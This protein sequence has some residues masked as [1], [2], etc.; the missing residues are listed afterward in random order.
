[1]T[2]GARFR[3][4]KNPYVVIA[5]IGI[6]A[7]GNAIGG[8][9]LWDDE[10]VVKTNMFIRQ[11][12]NLPKLLTPDYFAR[13]SVGHYTQ[14]G[15]ESYRPVVTLTHFMDYAVFGLRPWGYHFMNVLF[16]LAASLTLLY[17]FQALNLTNLAAFCAALLFMV[18]PLNSE[19]V[20]MVSYR[21]D[22][23]AGL[24]VSAAFAALL[25]DRLLICS[26]WYIAALLSKES[27]L[28]FALLVG[29]YWF[30]VRPENRRVSICQDRLRKP[31]LPAKRSTSKQARRPS[32]QQPAKGARCGSEAIPVFSVI[33]GISA[34]YLFLV[35]IVFPPLGVADSYELAA[36]PGVIGT[37][38]RVFAKYLQL[39]V[40]PVILR[41]DYTFPVS[42]SIWSLPALGSLALIMG[43][44]GAS[45]LVVRSRLVRF[46]IW[47]F[48]V[49]ALPVSGVYPLKN[50]IA[51]RYLYLPIMGWCGVAGIGIAWLCERYPRTQRWIVVGFALIIIW[52]VGLNIK[53]NRVWRDEISF[54]TEMIRV[55]PDSAKGHSGLGMA[56]FERR[57]YEKAERALRRSL[58]LNPHQTIALHNYGCILME[59]GK[60]HDALAA[61]SQVV[62]RDPNFVEA[63]YQAGMVYKELHE[64]E[65]A[66]VYLR[67]TLDLNPNFIPAKFLL[68]VLHQERQ[69]WSEAV[70]YFEEVIAVDRGHDRAIKNLGIIYYYQVGDMVKA[71]RYLRRYLELVPNDPQRE[72]IVQVIAAAEAL[73]S[74]P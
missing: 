7:Y 25:K 38:A 17:L 20:N 68:G 43:L 45:A 15:E 41:V 37:M 74:N 8:Q 60:P 30:Y 29:V 2:N 14:S 35:F 42:E 18:H 59:R 23:L 39:F 11:L 71:A 26:L 19:T 50:F 64:R 55:T 6:I 5:I 66:E 31:T 69:D 56:Y 51:E 27:A 72:T 10:Y 54:F 34:A 1:M 58:E 16:H 63:Y 13:A 4:L 12:S 52:F 44:L 61:F 49:S 3:F 36:I 70:S 62:E 48:L 67:K 33:G 47:W 28:S 32:P 57:D 40:A 53:R 65:Q 24:F 22:L 46:L 9:L 21:E 73:N